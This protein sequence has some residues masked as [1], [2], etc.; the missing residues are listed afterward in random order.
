MAKEKKPEQ[1]QTPKGTFDILPEDQKYWDRVLSVARGV[2]QSYGFEK[3]DTPIF[4]DAEV[5]T[6]T[7]GDTTDIIE[8]QMYSVKSRGKEKLVLRPEGTAGVARAYIDH[9]MHQLPQPQKFFYTGP[10]FRHEQPQAGRYRQFHQFGLETIGDIDPIYDAEV[11]SVLYQTLLKLE[12]KNLVVEINSIGCKVCRPRYKSALLKYYKPRVKDMCQ[13]C[14]RRISVN[15]LRLLDCKEEVCQPH[16]KGAPHSVDKLCDECK[17]HFKS[18]L[19]YLDELSVPY[20]LNPYL[21]R[22]LDYY[23]KTAFEIFYEEEITQQGTQPRVGQSALGGGGRYDD[24]IR[25]LSGPKAPA[26]GGALGFERVIGQMKKQEVKVPELWE[27]DV[28]VVQ[29]GPS[30]KRKALKVFEDLR[31]AGIKTTHA[32]GKDSLKSQLTI[33]NRLK[34]KIALIIGQKEIFDETIIVREMDSGVQ[35]TIP[36]DRLLDRLKEKMKV[37]RRN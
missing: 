8:K 26:V 21:V 37:E 1:V 5:Y 15:P 18:V 24:L 9:G 11:I 35:E 17:T 31:K 32:F 30:A 23:T 25:A 27:P 28:L 19:E 33:G 12:L 29:I 13:D 20:L 16:K 14:K 10:F 7:V 4:E 36:M 2:A 6:R 22:G 34:V 3:I